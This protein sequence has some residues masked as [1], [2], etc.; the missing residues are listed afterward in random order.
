MVILIP[1]CRMAMGKRGEGLLESQRRKSG[2]GFLASRPSTILSRAGS[3]LVMRWQL[4]RNTQCPAAMPSWIILV[5]IGA[6]TPAQVQHQA[7]GN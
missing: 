5:A 2:W 1:L 3:Q 7:P 4:A 6:C